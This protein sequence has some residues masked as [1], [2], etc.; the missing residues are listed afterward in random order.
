MLPMAIPAPGDESRP[1]SADDA[2]GHA[3]AAAEPLSRRDG[4][5]DCLKGLAIILVVAGHTAQGSTPDFDNLFVFRAIYSFHMPMFMFVAGMVIAVSL[6]KVMPVHELTAT[7]RSIASGIPK[8]AFRLLIPFF[9]WG[10]VA[11]LY[12]GRP[13]ET[14]ASWLDKL[15]WTPDYG[16]WFLL[17]L[18]DCYLVL[19]PCMILAAAFLVS[20]GPD[21]HSPAYRFLIVS[22]SLLIGEIFLKAVPDGFGFAFARAYFPFVALGI[23]YQMFVP[24]GLPLSL[25]I[26]AWALFLLLMPFWYRLEGF[27]FLT[28]LPHSSLMNLAL[29]VVTALAG[30][31]MTIDVARLLERYGHRFVRSAIDR[32]GRRSLEIYALHYYFLGYRPA[33]VAP[34]ALSLTVALLLRNV[35]IV[36]ALLFGEVPRWQ[37]ETWR[38]L[39]GQP[40]TQSFTGGMLPAGQTVFSAGPNPVAT[41]SRAEE[42]GVERPAI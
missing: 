2:G 5:L 4:T 35:P 25:R 32:C 17:A 7:V 16:L 20:G 33:I 29:R 30:T 11:L 3:T 1:G 23:L 6:R 24:R 12:P 22:L 34:I 41:I 14:L 37:R 18:F 27:S 10:V 15:V 39:S 21:R 19:S 42:H 8:R 13:D 31:S 36:G 26:G 28:G 40:A 38:R 9:A